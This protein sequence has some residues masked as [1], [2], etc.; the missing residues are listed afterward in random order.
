MLGV[1]LT[2]FLDGGFNR[3]D[4]VVPGMACATLAIFVGAA[5]HLLTHRRQTQ[6][7]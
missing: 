4:L 5:A 6:A 1:I 7:L 2:Y 3:P